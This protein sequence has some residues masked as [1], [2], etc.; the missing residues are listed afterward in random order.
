MASATTVKQ[1]GYYLRK[2]YSK[3]EKERLMFSKENRKLIEDMVYGL[4]RYHPYTNYTLL[5]TKTHV[6]PSV[7]MVKPIQT[8]NNRSKVYH[9][10]IQPI[11]FKNMIKAVLFAMQFREIAKI[12]YDKQYQH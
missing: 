2:R 12:K 4:Y 7:W 8:L 1:D 11:Y 3:D 6:K 10:P 5:L 9:D